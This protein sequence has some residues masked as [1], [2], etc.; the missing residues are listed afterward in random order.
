MRKLIVLEGADGTG[1]TT[2]SKLLQETLNARLV[3]QPAGDGPVGFLRDILKNR[4]EGYNPFELQCLHTISHVVDVFTKFTNTEDE[5]LVM[6]RSHIS[7]WVYGAVTIPR[8]SHSKL[9]TLLEIH[10]NLY[11][12]FLKEFQVYIVFLHARERQVPTTTDKYEES[13]SWR[14]VR[15]EYAQAFGSKEYWFQ[16]QEVLQG[17]DVTDLSPQQTHE[18]ILEIINARIC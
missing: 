17:I 6:D 1:K 14:R 18:R 9:Y 15:M 8:E 12:E 13:Y 5:I 11:R 3:V 4:P 7:L 2:Q 10:Y 16:P